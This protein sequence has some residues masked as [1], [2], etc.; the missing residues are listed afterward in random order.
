MIVAVICLNEIALTIFRDIVSSSN[1]VATCDRD[2]TVRLF[3]LETLSQSACF[4]TDADF[5]GSRLHISPNGSLVATASY[6]NARAAVY[7]SAGNAL[8]HRG[9][10]TDI[11]VV[12]FSPDSDILYCSYDRGTVSAFSAHDGEPNR[13]GW[14]KKTIGGC[15]RLYE[16][17]CD[18]RILHDRI[19]RSFKLTTKNQKSVA[20][21]PRKTFGLLD[22]AFAPEFVCTSESTGPISCY[23]IDGE[24]VWQID[25]DDGTHALDLVYDKNRGMFLAITWPYEDGGAQYLLSIQPS[26]GEIVSSDLL[27]ED[28]SLFFAKNGTLLISSTGEVF[29][30]AGLNQI[31]AFSPA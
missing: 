29:E 22:V 18:D 30:T 26:T 5:G 24:S 4:E 28:S 19:E 25:H 12:R 2:G 8:W 17:P 31:G 6:N 7:D 14:F 16:S 1:S 3:D 13:F 15:Y 21:L 20:T 11:Q 27:P 23:H 10:L 9:N